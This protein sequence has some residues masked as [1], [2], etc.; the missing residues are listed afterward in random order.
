MHKAMSEP[1]TASKN[2]AQEVP[3]E[4]QNYQSGL[5]AMHRGDWQQ[6]VSILSQEPETSVFYA[7]ANANLA[8]AYLAL[9]RGDDAWAVSTTAWQAMT[10]RTDQHVSPPSFIQFM[11]NRAEILIGNGQPAAAIGI[12]NDACDEADELI[13]DKPQFAHDIR[14]QKA[15]AIGVRAQAHVHLGQHDDAIAQFRSAR[16]V[17]KTVSDN[18]EG[19]AELLTNYAWELVEAGQE[20]TAALALDE[21]EQIATEANNA[22]QLQRITD[23]R[24]MLFPD[25]NHLHEH[26]QSLEKSATDAERESNHQVAWLRRAAAARQATQLG[27]TAAGLEAINKAYAIEPRL[28]GGVQNLGGL[29]FYHAMLLRASGASDDE[30]LAT[31]VEGARLLLA[32]VAHPLGPSDLKNIT[33]VMHDHFR[34]TAQLLRSEGRNEESFVAFEAGRALAHAIASDAT[35]RERLA[36][37]NPFT[38]TSGATRV[39]LD[40]LRIAQ[41][42]LTDEVIIAPVAMV[43]ELIA[44]VVSRDRVD[45]VSVSL[46]L[47]NLDNATEFI[48]DALMIPIRLQDGKGIDAV[49]KEIRRLADE[50]AGVVGTRKI[51][52]CMPHAFLHQV[53]WRALLRSAGLL[54]EKLLFATEFGLIVRE[55]TAQ[56]EAFPLRCTAIGYDSEKAGKGPDSFAEE[57]KAFANAIGPEG[58]FLDPCTKRALEIAL[59]HRGLAYVSSHAFARDRT[60]AAAV[61]L[62]LSDATVSMEDV[63]PERLSGLGILLSACESGVFRVADGD[64]PVGAVPEI[65]RRGSAFVIGTRFTIRIGF[66][67]FFFPKFGAQLASGFTPTVGMSD[68]MNLAE[69]AGYDLW[70]DLAAVEM[71][72][73][74][75]TK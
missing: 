44:Y 2:Q 8:Q 40:L 37:Q 6:A 72:R 25:H 48:Q 49:A 65:L 5:D 38:E 50:I 46:S 7:P 23:R 67:A 70:R 47:G 74:Q 53:P 17:Y 43:G 63:L 52:S 64:Y 15:H 35:S 39:N 45:C 55:L 13:L 61:W 21:A 11:R 59:Q 51:V 4:A 56:P 26:F 31:L 10:T 20:T 41:S 18:T 14:V 28:R 30:V 9:G 36:I 57:A 1:K 22:Q 75:E 19:V 33:G 34:L 73:H 54:W 66:A 29:R 71:Y 69:A 27:Q 16:D 62:K 58:R 42:R 3:R 68:T 60:G 12:I 24:A 32:R